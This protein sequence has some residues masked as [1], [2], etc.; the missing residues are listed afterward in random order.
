MSFNINYFG[1]IPYNPDN[2]PERKY[3]FGPGTNRPIGLTY[4]QMFSAYWTVRSFYINITLISIQNQDLLGQFASAG[5]TAGG[6]AGASAALSSIGSSLSSNLGVVFQG[7]TKI[8]EKYTK[9]IRIQPDGIHNGKTQT[10]VDL[11]KSINPNILNSYNFNVNEGSL[12]SAGPVHIFTNSNGSSIIDM[13]D[14][15]YAQRL[16]WPLININISNGGNITVSNIISSSS[17]AQV[18]GS[19]LFNNIGPINMYAYSTSTD[20][21]SVPL[22]ELGGSISVQNGCCDRFFYDGKNRLLDSD[23]CHQDCQKTIMTSY[24]QSSSSLS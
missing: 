20:S 16:Y 8:E 6:I 17:N 12:C 9:K 13:S 23:P 7:N 15:I 24:S 11:D 22:I 10:S 4:S 5:G 14:V 3:I 2:L 18:L 1:G 21:T 19:V